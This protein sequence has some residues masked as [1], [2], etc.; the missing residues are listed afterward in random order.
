MLAQTAVTEESGNGQ[1]AKPVGPAFKVNVYIEAARQW[2]TS[3]TGK[4]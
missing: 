3:N 4:R 1:S 2:I